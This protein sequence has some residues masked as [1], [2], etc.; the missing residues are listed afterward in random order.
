M[1]GYFQCRFTHQLRDGIGKQSKPIYQIIACI[2]PPSSDMNDFP[3]WSY[4][5]N[6]HFTLKSTYLSIYEAQQWEKEISF[7]F[8][9]VWK[10]SVP[11]RIQVFL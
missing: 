4:S 2:E 6:N 10:R 3:S 8:N 9:I 5:T 1:G 11:Q 7:P